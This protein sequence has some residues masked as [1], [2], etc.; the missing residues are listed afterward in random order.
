MAFLLSM[1]S[2]K[3]AFKYGLAYSFVI[4]IV[5]FIMGLILIRY[6][7]GI[8]FTLRLYVGIA[9][10]IAAAV[11]LKDF[12]FEGKGFSLR[13][14]VS[15]KPLIEKYV[16]KGT[17]TAIL[18]LGAFVSIVELPCSGI[19]YLGIISLI[20]QEGARGIFY[21]AVYNLIFILPLVF[22]TWVIYRGTQTDKINTWVQKNKKYMR[23]A[24]GIIMIL[25]AL[26]LLGVI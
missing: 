6:A 11:E 25:L 5:Y 17:F 14:P 7:I 9:L 26:S 23:L 10:L 21:L 16:R 20:A 8:F 2:S 1:S 12:F 24:A 15:A 13:I 3:R 18:I 22:L 4:F 19:V